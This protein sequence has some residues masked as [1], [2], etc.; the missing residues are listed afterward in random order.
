MQKFD[1]PGH[2]RHEEDPGHRLPANVSITL[3]FLLHIRV[4]LAREK[5]DFPDQENKCFCF[6]TFYYLSD[7]VTAT[8]S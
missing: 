3:L 4:I 7:N 1:L 8:D 5:M 2:A 6:E